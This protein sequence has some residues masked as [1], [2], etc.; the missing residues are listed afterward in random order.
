MKSF[1]LSLF[2]LL[3]CGCMNPPQQTA[4]DP[5]L[6]DPENNPWIYS[7]LNKASG[8]D[9]QLAEQAYR[10]GWQVGL[11]QGRSAV[12]VPCQRYTPEQRALEKAYRQG[13]FAG[14]AFRDGDTGEQISDQLDR[15]D[16]KPRP[17]RK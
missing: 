10:E 13:V 5:V 17:H 16:S 6:A 4:R 7:G 2:L 1:A 14:A 9:P 8:I 15:Q 12:T 3:T 11:R